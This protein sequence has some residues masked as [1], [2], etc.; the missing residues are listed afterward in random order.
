MSNHY[1]SICLLI[2]DSWANIN[3]YASSYILYI[4]KLLSYIAQ[5]LLL[6]YNRFNAFQL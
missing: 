2:K 5:K 1:S 4:L 6:T 3:N